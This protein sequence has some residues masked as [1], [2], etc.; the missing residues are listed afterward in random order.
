MQRRGFLWLSGATLVLLVLAIVALATGNGGVSR[1]APGERALP[2]LGPRL[3]DLAWMRLT[4]GATKMDFAQIGKEWVLVE[5]GNYPA[6]PGKIRQVLLALADLTLIEPKT[7]R[8]ELYPRLDVDDPA[9][10]KATLVSVQDKSGET[11]AELIV[12][13][14]RYDRLGAG[15]DG[16]YVR[17]PGDDR[18]WLARGSLDLGGDPQSWLDRR[19]LDIPDKRIA[20]VSLTGADGKTLVISRTAP[21]AEFGVQGAPADAKVKSA[22]V[23]G[24]PATALETLDLD[25]VKPAA[26][27]PVPDSGVA[28]AAYTTFDGLTVHLRLFERD[29]TNWV[30]IDATGN[31]AAEAES[32]KLDDKVLRWTY[33]I[34]AFKANMLRTKL[35]DLIEPPP[36]G[37]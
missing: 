23:I 22:A 18:A 11:V 21:D 37:S 4:R 5:K 2:G 8:T 15:N 6:A 19:I 1:A 17:K 28:T 3:G 20:S 25:D 34:P 36:K 33:A 7:R 13:K 26:D 14:R 31:G 16:V 35:A 32:K 10:G 12:G 27:M 9:N 24:E 29:K 30:A